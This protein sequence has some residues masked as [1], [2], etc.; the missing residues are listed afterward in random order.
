M[1][2]LFTLMTGDGTRLTRPLQLDR[3]DPSATRS[4]SCAWS[5]PAQLVAAHG[6]PAGHADARQRDAPEAE[7]RLFGRGVRLQT[8][9][10][11]EQPNP[12]FIP[13]ADQAARWLAERI[14]GI[15]AERPHRVAL[16][17]SRPP[18]TSSAAP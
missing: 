6:D 9:Q 15:A 14:G 8:E 17:T 18:P 3:R 2:A 13:A 1:S 5:D 7:A 16:Q 10:D 12:T 11:P 4:S